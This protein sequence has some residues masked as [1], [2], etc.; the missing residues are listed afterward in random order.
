MTDQRTRSPT[1]PD[2]ILRDAVESFDLQ[3]MQDADAGKPRRISG[4]AKEADKVN[5]NRRFFSLAVLTGMCAAA[6][7]A[8][9]TGELYGLVQ[10][11]DPWYEGPKGLIQ[12]VGIKYDRLWMDGPLLKFE[13]VVVATTQGRDLQ[14][15]LDA[16]VKVGMSTNVRGSARYLPAKEVDPEWPDPEETIQVVNDDARLVTI[17]AV[18]GP[19]DLAGELNAADSV[20]E[21]DHVKDLA[22]LKAKYPALYDQAVAAGKQE[23]GANTLE[24]QLASE[25]TARLALEKKIQD[26]GRKAIATKALTDANLP[27]LGKSGDIDL[28]ARFEKR[29]TDAAL[30]AENE[31]EARAEVAA[32]IAERKVNTGAAQDEANNPGLDTTTTV[33]DAKKTTGKSRSTF[34]AARRS[35]GL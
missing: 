31:D 28:D 27:K 12:N 13:G 19:A 17:D 6:Q 33:Q 16:G 3:P 20:R 1:T 32:L 7:D 34:S 4:V 14:A 9:K 30:R 23:A 25:R 26:D 22:E 24:D 35:F 8:L 2:G 5:L 29:V 21:E 11:P 15:V 10:H 18:M